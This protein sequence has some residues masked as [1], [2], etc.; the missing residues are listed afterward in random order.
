MK[1]NVA[2]LE[3]RMEQIGGDIDAGI[4]DKFYWVRGRV[5]R[6][7]IVPVEKAVC[8]GCHLNIPPQMYNELHRCDHLEFCPHCQRIIYCKDGS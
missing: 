2:E 7:A 3:K 8:Q 1:K 4:L 5:G 6:S